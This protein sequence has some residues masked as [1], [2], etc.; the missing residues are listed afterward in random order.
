MSLQKTYNVMQ[1]LTSTK[2]YFVDLSIVQIIIMGIINTNSKQYFQ[3]LYIE[4]HN[5]LRRQ[6][7]N[8]HMK[9]LS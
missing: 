1:K 3:Q 8:T 5:Y 6:S 9:H 4:N 7:H 2:K